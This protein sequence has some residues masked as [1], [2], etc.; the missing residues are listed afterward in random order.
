MK[1][2]LVAS[3]L[4]LTPVAAEAAVWVVYPTVR[5]DMV[6]QSPTGQG[7]SASATGGV[8]IDDNGVQQTA[9]YTASSSALCC[10]RDRLW[11]VSYGISN[12]GS[13][14][15]EFVNAGEFPQFGIVL[16][17]QG[18]SFQGLALQAFTGGM[19]GS[20]SVEWDGLSVGGAMVSAVGLVPE[21]G[22][23]ALLSL[24]VAAIGVRRRT[25]LRRASGTAPSENVR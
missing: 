7:I 19:G 14:P 17:G 16:P 9:G 1:R 10:T 21:P 2:S 18:E 5:F 11:Q 3:L 4:V 15:F 13:A 6:Y 23:L 8:Y 25:A 22:T 20:F 24:G 12:T